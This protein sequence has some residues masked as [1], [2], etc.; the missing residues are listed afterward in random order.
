[1]K[2]DF[3]IES[4]STGLESLTGFAPNELTGKPLASLCP[5]KNLVSSLQAKLKH[6]YFDQVSTY[7]VPKAGQSIQISISGFYLGL[8]SDIN[9]LIILK[10][11]PAEDVLRL[12]Q[13][14]SSQRQEMDSFIY[15]TAHDLRGPLATIKGLVNLLKLR[16]HDGEVDELT[17]L[18]EVHANKLD[19]R[20][21]KLLYLANVNNLPKDTKRVV[22]FERLH[23]TL[24]KLR[25]D[26]CQ[27]KHSVLKFQAPEEDLH[28]VNEYL[29]TQLISNIFLYIFSQPVASISEN[30]DLTVSAIFEV[31]ESQLEIRIVSSG[32]M[33]ED[34]LQDV[35]AQPSTLYNNLLTYP[36]LFNYY[37]A[38]KNAA[39]LN[40]SL[41][42]KFIT[43]TKQEL[44]VIVPIQAEP[45]ELA[46]IRTKKTY[47]L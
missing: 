6:G 8:I 36:F 39:Q 31:K 40:A 21:F 27:L 38:I 26:N 5:D 47:A 35:I 46:P 2:M 29:L 14:L 34:H 30:S 12:K 9:E 23:Q 17:S 22:R 25:E 37:V 4:L 32:F 24:I 18:I 20:L 28:G 19:D 41:A 1:M 43:H 16:K 7:L 10:V 13:E 44:R 33:I 15:R 11:K 42:V 3:T 45:I